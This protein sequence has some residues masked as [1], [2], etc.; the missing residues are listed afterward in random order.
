MRLSKKY[1]GLQF[2]A[3]TPEIHIMLLSVENYTPEHWSQHWIRINKESI[4][5]NDDGLVARIIKDGD[6]IQIPLSHSSTIVN[7]TT[8]DSGTDAETV[9]AYQTDTTIEVSTAGPELPSAATVYSLKITVGGG[10]Y[11]E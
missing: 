5:P 7:G 2:F 11:N 6:I 10:E 1:G 9:I 4:D 8:Y 3:M